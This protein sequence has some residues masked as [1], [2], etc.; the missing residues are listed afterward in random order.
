MVAQQQQQQ[1][2]PD[3]SSMSMGALGGGLGG[4]GSSSGGATAEVTPEQIEQIRRMV[5]Y[6]PILTGPLLEQ[7]RQEDPDLYNRIGGDPEKLLTILSE[8]GDDS[9]PSASSAP[10][11]LLPPSLPPAP[12]RLQATAP[13]LA[14]A[15]L[16]ATAPVPAPFP[17][18][19]P[20]PR[21]ESRT[22]SV[23]REESEQIE[24]VCL[25]SLLSAVAS[26]DTLSL[27]RL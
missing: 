6:N 17:Q 4:G 16:Q 21:T 27:H 18:G 23:T 14:P 9:G 3:L 25:P 2:L 13:V 8:V 12:A 10:A 26:A 19:A 5:A 15:R 22:I 1:E 7:F 20:Q 24:N 11:S